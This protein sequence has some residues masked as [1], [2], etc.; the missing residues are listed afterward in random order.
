MIRG[1]ALALASFAT[2]PV[3]AAPAD[4][5]G[6]FMFRRAIDVRA[7]GWVLVRL[8]AEA[9]VEGLPGDQWRVTAPGGAP[10][11]IAVLR[12]ASGE[13]RPR[14]IG[15]AREGAE[16]LL[17]F[18]LGIQPLLHTRF[19]AVAGVDAA[20]CLLEA[21]ADLREWRALSQ[22]A[23]FDSDDQPTL[24]PSMIEY[25]PATERFLRLRWPAAAGEPDLRAVA[26]EALA[27]PPG[28]LV[29]L[30]VEARPQNV[31]GQSRE[32][33]LELPSADLPVRRIDL[34]FT[35]TGV[36]GF[37]VFRAEPERWRL[38]AEREFEAHGEGPHKISATL[39]GTALATPSLRVQLA[40]AGQVDLLGCRIAL[41]PAWILFRAERAGEHALLSWAL[42]PL[43]PAEVA[44][45]PAAAAHPAE[46]AR[47]GP[48]KLLAADTATPP[49]AA[50][51]PIVVPRR[52]VSW[53]VRAP[54]VAPGQLVVLE[55]PAGP[56]DTEALLL[57]AGDRPVP[58]VRAIQPGP[59]LF[60]RLE[61]TPRGGA[62]IAVG[63]PAG[64]GAVSDAELLLH[65]PPFQRWVDLTATVEG[66]APVA[67]FRAASWTC[68]KLDALPCRLG[69]QVTLPVSA[70][71]LLFEIEG[72]PIEVQGQ[73]ELVLWRPRTALV[74]T[75]PD[76][77]RL[78]L[79]SGAGQGSPRAPELEALGDQLLRRPHVVA[80]LDQVVHTVTPRG[81]FRPER[82]L[83][84]VI[85][86]LA[87]AAAILLLARIV[88][89]WR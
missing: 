86:L 25:A 57:L 46:E 84:A 19:K 23:L 16:W 26:V 66:A 14:A 68:P 36:V 24:L 72:G 33:L 78:L 9:L 34:E 13:V 31:R 27:E 44:V 2:L 71:E 50:A 69:L 56:A 85:L 53:N 7:P 28:G 40:S 32:W 35:G 79:V 4:A 43:G 88:R 20:G 89:M 63:V 52:A 61:G 10:L 51:K 82:V 29:E 8:D 62:A 5:P 1:A 74:F 73:P 70:H 17:T 60:A 58:F 38:F 80:R 55:L 77:E 48:P 45:D 54:G 18:D 21:S 67:L 42:R 22:G 39:P 49:A 87:G 64:T 37:R 65:A 81:A 12:A 3:L 41:S 11:P 15:R 59:Q 47:L 30:P 75:W 6:A 76:R 83:G